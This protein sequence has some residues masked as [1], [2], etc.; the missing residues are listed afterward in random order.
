M[1]TDED[2]DSNGA[3]SPG[4]EATDGSDDGSLLG[5]GLYERLFLAVIVPFFV[6]DIA[7]AF[8]FASQS[9]AGILEVL[10]IFLAVVTAVVAFLQ[11]LRTDKL[12]GRLLPILFVFLGLWAG[13]AF[14]L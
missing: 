11:F 5:L 13:L 8:Y 3:D 10:T 12:D 1:S 6:G 9:Y 14:G 4:E 2:G 7:G